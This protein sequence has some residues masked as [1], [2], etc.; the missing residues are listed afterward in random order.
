[1]CLF[2]LVHLYPVLKLKSLIE[3]KDDP[4]W[5]DSNGYTC[6]TYEDQKWC[7]NGNMDSTDLTW[8]MADLEGKDQF[9]GAHCCACGKPPIEGKRIILLFLKKFIYKMNFTF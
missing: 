7:S 2:Y 5:V 1:M 8:Y 4:N 6:K 3:C 9:P